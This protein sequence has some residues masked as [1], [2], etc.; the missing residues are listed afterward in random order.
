MARSTADGRL[1][2]AR[3]VVEIGCGTARFAHGLLA[4]VCEAGCRYVGLDVS[5]RMCRIAAAGLST[6]RDRACVA[7]YGGSL[8]LP[9]RSASADRVAAAFLVDLLPARYGRELLADAH[10]V[11]VPGGL[12]GLASLTYGT[13]PAGR[14]F[15][16]VWGAPALGA[17]AARRCS[18]P[19]AGRCVP[20]QP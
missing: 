10:R 20:I 2:D 14:A 7:L 12:L 1:T 5:A 15:S 19:N 4:D 11:L 8:P 6:W 13:T 17:D 16:T 9:L 18:S 3:C